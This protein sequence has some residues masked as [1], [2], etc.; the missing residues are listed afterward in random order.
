MPITLFT[1][2]VVGTLIT[3]SWLRRMISKL[4]LALEMQQATS[5][6]ENSNT[7]CQPMVMMFPSTPSSPAPRDPVPNSVGSP[8]LDNLSFGMLTCASRLNTQPQ[9]THSS[10]FVRQREGEFRIGGVAQDLYPE[11]FIL[12]PA[13]LPLLAT[14]EKSRS[15]SQGQCFTPPFYHLPFPANLI[16]LL[17]DER[18]RRR[19]RRWHAW[20][21]R[22]AGPPGVLHDRF[23]C[24]RSA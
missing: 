20:R 11:A 10:A 6:G 17:S 12:L 16:P 5:D 1:R 9:W 22:L 23:R 18:H 19:S 14:V 24:V 7:M 21:E 15:R 2:S 3:H 8:T 13:T 4:W